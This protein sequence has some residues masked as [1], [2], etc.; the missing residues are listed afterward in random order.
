MTAVCSS[1]VVIDDQEVYEQITIEDP[2]KI[3]LLT[4]PSVTKKET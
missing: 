3:S 4:K 2:N 1:T